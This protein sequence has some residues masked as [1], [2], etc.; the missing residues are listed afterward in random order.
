LGEDPEVMG[1]K[2]FD[3]VSWVRQDQPFGMTQVLALNLDGTK[4]DQDN[5]DGERK[6]KRTSMGHFERNAS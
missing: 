5:L 2:I 1:D 4:I 6:H 3:Q